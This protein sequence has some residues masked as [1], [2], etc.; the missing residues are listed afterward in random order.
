ME[1]IT[2][3]RT[4]MRLK[5]ETLSFQEFSCEVCGDVVYIKKRTAARPVMLDD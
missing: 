1:H 2:C 5:A 3:C 4:E